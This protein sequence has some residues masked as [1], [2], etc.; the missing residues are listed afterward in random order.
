M[1]IGKLW[2]S[3]R[4]QLNKLANFFWTADPIAQMQYEYDQAV[5]QLKGG[6]EGLAQ[7]RA[8][9][10]KVSQQAN[11]EKTRVAQLE[12][13]VKAYLQAGDRATAAKFALD[14]QKAK[15]SLA[16]KVSQMQMHET[17]YENNVTKI[18]NATKKV[19]EIKDKMQKY[20]AELKMSRAEAEMAELTGSLNFDITTDMGQIEQVL[21]DQINRN[22]AKVRVASDLSEQGVDDI[23]RETAAEGAM[24]EDALKQFEAE[25]GYLTPGTAQVSHEEKQLGPQATTETN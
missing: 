14:L 23:L 3:F 1:I 17:S 20:D 13:R 7:Y 19:G 11:A 9:V 15:E 5:D 4:A 18:R 21:Q 24:A 2:G 10:E 6:R 12:G 25:M 16:D 22:R 8:L